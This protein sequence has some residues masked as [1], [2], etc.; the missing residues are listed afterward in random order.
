MKT[1]LSLK[2]IHL[3]FRWL[4]ILNLE[5]IFF[6]LYVCKQYVNNCKS[7]SHYQ[8]RREK[9]HREGGL[10]LT[11]AL[12]SWKIFKKAPKL[13]GSQFRVFKGGA[14]LV[15]AA[16]VEGSDLKSHLVLSQMN[17]RILAIIPSPRFFFSCEIGRLD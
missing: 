1:G 16:G 8:W 10:L 13:L 12:I 14:D 11:L 5:K 3:C 15:E 9:D 7:N 4:K 2:K 6:F 17:E